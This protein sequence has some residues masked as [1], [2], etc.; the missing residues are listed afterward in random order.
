[1]TLGFRNGR[2]RIPIH[3][4]NKKIID[5][6]WLLCVLANY[7]SSPRWVHTS[8]ACRVTTGA[9]LSTT[10]SA[11]QLRV[12]AKGDSGSSDVGPAMQDVHVLNKGK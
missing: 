4:S 7:L 9:L 6:C 12:S 1:M 8:L 3:A 10:A 11:R 2:K 5:T